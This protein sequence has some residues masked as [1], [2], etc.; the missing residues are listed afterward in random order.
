MP[1]YDED[2]VVR[3]ESSGSGVATNLI[4]AIT[5]LIITGLLF[6]A[7]FYSNLFRSNPVKK[8]GVDVNVSAPQ[9]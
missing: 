1:I 8:I 2:V 7:V 9:R 6:W 3:R 4:W 5:L